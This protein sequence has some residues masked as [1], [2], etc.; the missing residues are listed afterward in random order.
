MHRLHHQ[1]SSLSM[2]ACQGWP[3]AT[4]SQQLPTS[5]I[6]TALHAP[7]LSDKLQLLD[8]T[9]YL[10]RYYSMP[11]VYSSV[12]ARL[13]FAGHSDRCNTAAEALEKQLPRL[14]LVQA[15]GGDA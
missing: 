11:T 3:E 12:T 5:T 1:G 7:H 9:T 6:L 15:S 8:V 14:R 4:T 10:G 2:T 13:N